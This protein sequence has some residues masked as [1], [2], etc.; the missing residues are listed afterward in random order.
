LAVK[1]Y[2][3]AFYVTAPSALPQ[4]TF[5][6]GGSKSLSNRALLIRHLAGGTSTLEG[7]SN[8]DDT[9]TMQALLNQSSDDYN[10]G[11]AGT[12]YRFMCARLSIKPG[13]QIL[14][15]TNRMHKRPIKPLVQAL[16]QMGA[17]I[18]YLDKPGYPP[19]KIGPP[20]WTDVR[21]TVSV[22]AG[23]S[24]QFISALMMIGPVLP[25]GL[26]I[27]MIP[28]VASE[29]YIRMTAEV[30]K[31]F[32]A[33][34]DY[35]DQI[36]QISP[37]PYSPTD[38]QIETD[39]SSAAYPISLLA[40]ANR[41]SVHIP[42]LLENSLQGDQVIQ[43]IAKGWGITFEFSQEG[44]T[45]RAGG[46]APTSDDWSYDFASCPDLAPTVIAVQAARNLISF[47]S[48]LD[49]LKLKESD[50]I[51]VMKAILMQAGMRLELESGAQSESLYTLTGHFASHR[52]YQHRPSW[53]PPNG[54][55]LLA[56]VDE[57]ACVNKVTVCS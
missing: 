26:N 34:I 32:G 57:N 36:I 12:C 33:D 48:G 39:W 49:N 44:L 37:R 55:G 35:V 52:P 47:F 18:E 19:L 7:L 16:R 23:I 40:L 56:L 15:G 38:Y 41:G 11:P 24:S 46:D 27:Q 4:A 5:H 54:H 43:G 13:T 8:S 1:K 30:M 51:E 53:R 45:A 2:P 31:A 22:E 9:R 21:P 50:R 14:R 28:P 20:Q 42:G 10:A 17:T 6:P 3:A 29:S 25:Y